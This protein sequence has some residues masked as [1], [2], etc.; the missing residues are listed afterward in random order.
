ML[1]RTLI[2]ASLVILLIA[3]MAYGINCATMRML[4][5]LGR[6]PQEAPTSSIQTALN[7]WAPRIVAWGAAAAL[8][9]GVAATMYKVYVSRTRL[10]ETVKP[11][12]MTRHILLFGPTG[13]GKTST[14]MR[15]VELALRRGADV[16]IVDWKGEYGGYFRG[17]TIV[18]KLDLLKPDADHETYALVLTDILRDVL[19]LTDPMAYMLYDELVRGYRMGALTFDKLIRNLEARRLA[20]LQARSF[21]EANIAEGLIRRLYLL[22]LDEKRPAM[23]MRGSDRVVI[24]DL[25]AL[26]TYQLKCLYA[27]IILWRIYNEARARSTP[28]KKPSLS[29]LLILEESQNYIRPR[30]PERVPGIGERIVNELRA[31]GV[32]ALIISP[33][34]TQL[35]YHMARDAGAVIS[36]GYQGLPEVVAELLSF[37]R[38]SDVKRLIK[39]TSKMRTYIYYNGRLHIKG[40]PKPYKRTIDLGAIAREEPAGVVEERAEKVAGEAKP[41]IVEAEKPATRTELRLE[42]EEEEATE[43]EGAEGPRGPGRVDP[44][45]RAP[46]A[47]M[48][49]PMLLPP[50]GRADPRS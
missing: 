25:S 16:V 28:T 38:Y 1:K 18:R 6:K 22:A 27:E 37:Y 7:T 9:A 17:A 49:R 3:V 31:Y 4:E 48:R 45:G 46:D 30:R 19:E 40:V 13:S 26:T 34:P 12:D 10:L 32:G 14:A 42:E 11:A 29:K 5:K 43:A 2:A 47:H 15:A 33:D 20:A 41:V 8:L 50:R 44:I 35:P 21:A 36:I 23:N 39:T 24:Y